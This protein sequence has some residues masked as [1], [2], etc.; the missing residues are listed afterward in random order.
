MSI[1]GSCFLPP[2]GT[3]RSRSE[4]SSTSGASSTS[5]HPIFG[6]DGWAGVKKA[7]DMVPAFAI[8]DQKGQPLEYDAN[9]TPLA[10]FYVDIDAA[11]A[12]LAEARISAGPDVLLD[13][14]PYGL[15]EAFELCVE[16]KAVLI[17]SVTALKAAG[18]PP[19]ALPLGQAIPLFVCM[20]IMRETADGDAVLP[21]FLEADAA[22]SAVRQA[23]ETDGSQGGLEVVGLSLH[24]AVELLC[25]VP[26]TPAF[27]FVPAKRSMDHIGNY[28]AQN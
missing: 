18:A 2:Q 5:N 25:T 10:M 12:E 16:G 26:S 4:I 24:K 19:D 28:L 22:N 9:G 14:I 15:G 7:L 13:L 21:V 20:E 17:P 27:Q 6:S 8:A 3:V 11:K 1:G 23:M